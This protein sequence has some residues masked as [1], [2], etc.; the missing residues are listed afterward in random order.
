MKKVFTIKELFRK[1]FQEVLYCDNHSICITL[2]CFNKH[3]VFLH[4]LSKYTFKHLPR[5]LSHNLKYINTS[6][7]HFWNIQMVC[8]LA[9]TEKSG[10]NTFAFGLGFLDYFPTPFTGGM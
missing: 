8:S 2:Y 3:L 1:S 5:I 4:H 6:S 10:W 7:K 9:L